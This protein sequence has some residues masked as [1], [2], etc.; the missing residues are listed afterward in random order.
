MWISLNTRWAWTTMNGSVDIGQIHVF[1][2]DCRFL[3][4]RASKSILPHEVRWVRGSCAAPAPHRTLR[5]AHR[6]GANS[7]VSSRASQP[8]GSAGTQP[9]ASAVGRNWLATH[10]ATGLGVV[11]GGCQ[12]FRFRA[13][14]REAA[15]SPLTT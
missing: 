4:R 8:A 2:V 6:L 10:A 14:G 15:S 12:G 3:A 1:W 11:R 5:G 13:G 9:W 7:T